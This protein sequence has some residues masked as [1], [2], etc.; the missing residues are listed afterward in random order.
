[1][2]LLVNLETS[3]RF[4]KFIDSF[5]IE[6]CWSRLL[7]RSLWSQTCH[8]SYFY[9]PQ[10]NIHRVRVVT[11]SVFFSSEKFNLILSKNKSSFSTFCICCFWSILGSIFLP[12]IY[13]APVSLKLPLTLSFLLP[14]C[15]TV[16]CSAP[17]ARK[18]LGG[19]AAEK[20][21]GGSGISFS[22]FPTNSTHA[23]PF[24]HVYS[25]SSLTES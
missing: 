11:E 21:T 2:T 19:T 10:V 20:E 25:N 14:L 5:Q 12:Q 16:C 9:K 13:T 3:D 6:F 18:Q 23:F 22:F 7:R 1:M 8:M 17:W 4:H 15:F 24:L